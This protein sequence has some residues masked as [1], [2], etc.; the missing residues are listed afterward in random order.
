MSKAKKSPK[1]SGYKSKSDVY[2]YNDPLDQESVIRKSKRQATKD[3]DEDSSDGGSQ[4]S[5]DAEMSSEALAE[6]I[7]SLIGSSPY[8]H[9]ANIEAVIK[10]VR[11]GKF[12]I[13]SDSEVIFEKN[14]K[15]EIVEVRVAKK[16][17][18][19]FAEVDDRRFAVSAADIEKGKST[20]RPMRRY[21]PE[22][23]KKERPLSPWKTPTPKPPGM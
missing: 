6:Y 15:G 18:R 21:E 19:K 8:T 12:N 5:G 23:L 14:E 13:P 11:E 3:S 20:K 16:R 10:S 1:E 7:G 2:V 9:Q 4:G 17:D 22:E